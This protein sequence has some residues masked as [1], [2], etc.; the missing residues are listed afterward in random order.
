MKKA[1]PVFHAIRG[2][3]HIDSSNWNYRTPIAESKIRK[4]FKCQVLPLGGANFS[5]FKISLRSPFNLVCSWVWSIEK[6]D[7]NLYTTISTS[8]SKKRRF[9]FL[10]ITYLLYE[11]NAK[12]TWLQVDRFCRKQNR[13]A[14]TRSKCH[15]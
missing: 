5:S 8:A 14:F 7:C 2:V 1:P 3:S 6:L 4:A 13:F 10:S 11:N 12:E 15:I 9:C